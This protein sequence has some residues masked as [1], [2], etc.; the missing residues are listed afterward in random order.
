[1]QCLP[2]CSE[3]LPIDDVLRYRMYFEDYGQE[4]E[5]MR[6]YAALE[7]SAAVCATC[8]A[9][10]LGSCPLG[11]GIQERMAGAHRLLE[12]GRSRA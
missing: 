2:S 5:A 4:K 1:M 9:P 11:V 8:S 7:K 12:I 3:G 10:C 6:L